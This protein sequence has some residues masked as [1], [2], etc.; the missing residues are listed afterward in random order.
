MLARSLAFAAVVAGRALEQQSAFC[1][2]CHE[3][4]ENY[5][6]WLS[7]GAAVNH[8][9]CIECHKDPDESREA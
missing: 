4:R 1:A 9:T 5:D 7:S 3:E 2:S 8:K 6:R